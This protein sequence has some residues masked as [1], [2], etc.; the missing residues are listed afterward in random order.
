MTQ[1]LLARDFGG[2][3]I[4][5]NSLF[6]GVFNN[7]IFAYNKSGGLKISAGTGYGI[8]LQ[9]GA[10]CQNVKITGNTCN[11]ILQL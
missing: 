2:W 6:S 5:L 9:S 7:V 4:S 10:E 8:A 1:T 3:G 11:D